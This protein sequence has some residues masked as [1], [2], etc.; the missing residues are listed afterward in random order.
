[1]ALISGGQPDFFGLDIGTTAIRAVQLRGSGA[2]KIYVKHGEIE[3]ETAK[4]M[5]DAEMDRQLVTSKVQE[6]LKTAQITTRN[7]AVNLPSNKVFTAIVDMDKLPEGDLA[8][9]M[10]YQVGS[11]IPTPME[12]STVDWAVIGDSP[13]DAKKIEV[14]LTSALSDVIDAR[15]GM[16]EGIGLNV[17]AAEPDSMAIGRALVAPE[18]SAPQMIMDIG[19]IATDLVVIMNGVPHLTRAIP[20]GSFAITMAA[21]QNL[22]VDAV[23]ANQFVFKFGLSKDK[24]EGKVYDS[25][26]GTIE[27]VMSEVEKSIKFFTDRYGG[28]KISRLVLS[29]AASSIPE[30]PVHIV[31]RV[32]LN[33][34]IGNAWRNVNVPPALANELASVS[35]HF[36]VA[37]GLAERE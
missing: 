15:V 16:L 3:I 9:A 17:I 1:M 34:E 21:M 18:D 19:N 29:G 13:K 8:K 7:V 30:L 6:L 2:G 36:A 12:Q 37:T 10:Q 26:I 27:T 11:F 28:S 33:V 14:L 20:I 32:G 25:I 23:Q 4:M 31:N 5:S 22:G 24:L 35:N